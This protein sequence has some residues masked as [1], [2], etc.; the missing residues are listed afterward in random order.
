MSSVTTPA[1]PSAVSRSV[2]AA[3]TGVAVVFALNGL[4]IGSWFARVPAVREALDLTAGRLGLL[5][6]AMSAGA[7]VAMPTSG[8]VAQRLG[9]ARTVVVATLLVST[10]LLVAGVSA[11]AAGWLPGVA[12]GLFAFGYGTGT[13]DVAMNIEGAAVERRIGRTIMPRFHAAWSLGSVA[14]A[15]LGAVAAQVGL[16]V[17]VH[18]PLTAG[19]V[20]AGTALGARAFLSAVEPAPDADAVS[21]AARRRALLAAW[22]EPRTLLIG[23]FVLVAAFSEGAAT[24][25]VAVA[26]VDGYGVSEAA[27]AAVYGVFVIGMTI[28]RTAGTL[29]LDRWGRVPVL[30]GTILLAV[31]GVSVAVLAG[32]GPVAVAG[33][34]LWGLGVSLSFPMGMSAAADEEDRAPARVSVVAVIGYTAFLA[35]PPLLGL[36]G[37][38]VGTLHALLV[39]P[40]LLLPSL[41]LVPVT[42]PPR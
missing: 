36:L 2:L 7:V 10:G 20:L 27:G 3:R 21:P 34:A 11:S 1:A 38:R 12:V 40:I 29:A 42:R 4:A 35:G 9:T 32:S 16:A 23:L 5:L 28:G 8:L 19:A 26:F 24:D 18:L 39:V 17:A 41:A 22:R 30:G 25:W 6:L 33:V 14:G 15:G 31:L 37:D 13:C